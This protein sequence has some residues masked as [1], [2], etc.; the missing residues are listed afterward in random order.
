MFCLPR[1]VELASHELYVGFLEKVENSLAAHFGAEGFVFA[2]EL[3][4]FFFAD[5]RLLVEAGVA[6]FHHDV[7][8]AVENF[9]DL[10]QGEIQN[11]GDKGRQG[12]KEPDVGYGSSELDVAETLTAYLRLGYF[13]AALLADHAAI[14][15]A[16]VLAAKALVILDRAKDFGAEK[17][18]TLRLERTVVDRLRLLHFAKRPFADHF[19]RGDGDLYGRKAQRIFRLIEEIK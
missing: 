13:H 1:C 4:V 8:F 11:G 5:D 16:L 17:A 3:S 10:F 14:L 19:R 7:G 15:H 12:T 18:V 9:L 6:C 2:H